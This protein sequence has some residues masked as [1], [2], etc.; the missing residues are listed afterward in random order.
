MQLILFLSISSF[1]EAITEDDIAKKW[2]E[3][4]F[5]VIQSTSLE[6]CPIF[7]LPVGD[8]YKYSYGL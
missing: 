1:S 2:G 8:N 6:V 4:I 5:L 7:R 3:D